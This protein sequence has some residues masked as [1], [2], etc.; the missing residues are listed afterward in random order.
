M[1]RRHIKRFDEE[2]EKLYAELDPLSHLRTIPGIGVLLGPSL[3]GV[4]HDWKR[5]ASQRRMRGF[6]GLF[7][8]QN[9]SGGVERPGQKIGKGGNDR[10]KR[11]LVLAADVARTVDPELAQVY[12]RMMVEKGK[13]HRQALCA[14][15]TRLVNRI[16]AIMKRGRPY[17]LRDLNGNQINVVEAKKLIR[18]RF[19]V[20]AAVRQ[21]RIRTRKAVA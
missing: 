3:L 12:Y 9:E 2:I 21:S 8:R 13:H 18:D 6:C 16:H 15:A 19:T 10:A 7:P 5:F 4:L 17:Q 11:D 20:P 14:V 1:H